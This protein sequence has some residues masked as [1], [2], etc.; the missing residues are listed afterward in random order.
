M[1]VLT[2]LICVLT[3]WLVHGQSFSAYEHYTFHS[4]EDYRQ[5]E[6]VVREMAGYILRVPVDAANKDRTVA[7]RMV[8]Q[9]ATGTPDHSFTIDESLGPLMRKND[10]IVGLYVAAMTNYTLEHQGE[11][12]DANTRKLQAYTMLLN[13]CENR[14]NGVRRTKELDKAIQAKNNGSLPAYLQL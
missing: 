4:K 14:V 11:N 12:P 6:T 7:L 8:V 2:A 13:Y 3:P 5:Q 10:E 9:W 1:K